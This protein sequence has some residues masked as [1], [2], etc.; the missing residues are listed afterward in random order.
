[1]FAININRRSMLL[2]ESAIGL[3]PQVKKLENIISILIQMEK[4]KKLDSKLSIINTKLSKL[5]K[6]KIVLHITF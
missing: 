3:S 2:Y 6:S 5:F 1:M 4:D